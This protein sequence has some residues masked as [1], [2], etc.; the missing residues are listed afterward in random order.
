[1][2]SYKS[3]Q[4]FILSL[5][6]ILN[7]SVPTSA[8]WDQIGQDIDGMSD[9]EWYANSIS[10]N[11]DGTV[12]AIGCP[13][14]STNNL[15]GQV[16]VYRNDNNNW[17]QIGNDIENGDEGDSLGWSVSLNEDGTIVAVGAPQFGGDGY[18]RVFE[19][20][21]GN[22][23]QIGN[24]ITDT[25][26]RGHVGYSVD[27][28]ASGTTVAISAPNSLNGGGGSD[29]GR[30]RMYS[31]Q[32]GTWTQAGNNIDGTSSTN[33]GGT[34]SLNADG[35]I[36]AIGDSIKNAGN[37]FEGEAR[38]FQNQAGLWVQ[39]GQNLN[40]DEDDNFGSDVSLSSDGLTLAVSA[41]QSESNGAETGYTKVF[42]YDSDTWNLKGTTIL[43]DSQAKLFG[44]SL[45]LNGNGD[46]MVV[47]DLYYNIPS[48]TRA[49]KIHA[50]EFSSNDW[51]ELGE[52]V[53]GV[54]MIDFFGMAT[55][56]STDGSTV[57][58][59]GRFSE[60]LGFGFGRVEVYGVPILA[61]TNVTK[62]EF[63]FYPNPVENLLHLDFEMA[64]VRDIS[65]IDLSGKILLTQKL[66]TAKNSIDV[67]FLKSGFYLLKVKI[68]EMEGVF[69]IVKI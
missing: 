1:M 9:T 63:R 44:T 45:D 37:G 18:V 48:E 58:G 31:L 28:S 20:Q 55:S 51:Q 30:V 50:Y 40:G 32:G 64:K 46:K 62:K 52:G 2:K 65:I 25:D 54:V 6:L 23:I 49:G 13:G 24:T 57:S 21:T 17:I 14:Y 12:V 8:Q 33:S 26:F 3:S 15:F 67:S 36:V 56:I 16:R 68:A 34:I 10:L 19:N 61:N 27:I 38:V 43:P 29:N 66:H 4:N 11:G 22:W 47:A 60:N 42:S 35:S 59:S 69:K 7:F 5:F 53:E 41:T 39:I